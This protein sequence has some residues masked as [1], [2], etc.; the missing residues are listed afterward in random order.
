MKVWIVFPIAVFVLAA[1]SA[2]PAKKVAQPKA[3]TAAAVKVTKIP[4]GA[5]QIDATSYRYTA[6]D[7]KSKLYVKTPFGIMSADEQPVPAAS[8]DRPND[9]VKATVEGD[10][11]HF[12]R[13]SPFGVFRWQKKISD[14]TEQ[15][16][17]VWQGETSRSG[18]A[19]D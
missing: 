16:R 9:G 13:P 11:I 1:E 19:Q 10:T 2:P 4:D 5:V 14:L 3:A 7:G 6:P 8:N 17:A 18:S 15:E 12:E